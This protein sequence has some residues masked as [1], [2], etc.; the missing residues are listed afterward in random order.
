MTIEELAIEYE[1][2][3]N[4]L[5]DKVE[6]LK[7]LLQVYTGRDLLILRKKLNIYHDMAT[8]CELLLNAVNANVPHEHIRAMAGVQDMIKTEE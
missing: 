1:I 4:I 3:H 8:K 2:Q 7:P 6:A 5:A